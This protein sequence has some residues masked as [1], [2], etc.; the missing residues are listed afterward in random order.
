MDYVGRAS[1]ATLGFI[2]GDVPG[3]YAGYKAYDRLKKLTKNMKGY[4]TPKSIGRVSKKTGRRLSLSGTPVKRRKSV[5]SVGS[6]VST[7]GTR[8]MSSISKASVVNQ[9]AVSTRHKR[10]KKSFKGKKKKNVKVSRKLRA[11]IQK[12]IDG[13]KIYGLGRCIISGG[14]QS[15]NAASAVKQNVFALPIPGAVDVQKGVLFSPDFI[16]YCA[17]R[18]WNGRPYD[19]PDLVTGKWSNIDTSYSTNNWSNFSKSLGAGAL[20]TQKSAFCVNVHNLKA[21]ITIK[22]N[23]T[24]TQYLKMYECKPKY[25]DIN[26]V[27]L[28]AGKPIGDWERL[29]TSDYE[30]RIKGLAP[31]SLNNATGINSGYNGQNVLID[32]LYVTP[33]ICESWN[34]IWSYNSYDIV[35]EPGQVHTHW[36]QGD[37]GEYDFSKMYAPNSNG[38]SVY[39]NV[40]K[41]DRHIFFTSVPEMATVTASATGLSGRL[42]SS[43]AGDRFLFETEIFCSMSM[44][45]SAGTSIRVSEGTSTQTEV[46]QPLTQRKRAYFADTYWDS[47]S[48]QITAFTNTID[49]NNPQRQTS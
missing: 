37:V 30:A 1:A 29:L 11:K 31:L 28:N 25:Q 6:S 4:L 40:Q 21:K 38:V 36:V 43:N 27:Y 42:L 7:R 12:V 23:S 15:V 32:T 3:A 39:H 19:G 35:L 18:L 16:M 45:E 17:S 34:K 2:A 46:M 24:R 9:D 14:F 22:N 20:T 33:A 48:S 47:D 13:G 26:P 10:L 5:S 41:T 49:D 44:P 8:S